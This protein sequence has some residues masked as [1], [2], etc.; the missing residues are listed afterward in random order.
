[1]LLIAGAVK[2][3]SLIVEIM[4]KLIIIFVL[5]GFLGCS[6]KLIHQKTDDNTVIQLKLRARDYFTA[7][8]F[9]Q[10]KNEHEKALIE[11]YQALLYDSSSTTIYNRIAENHM[12]LGR[13]E[14]ALKY[15]QMSLK[16]NNTVKETYRLSADCYYSLKRD[17]QAISNLHKVLELDPFDMS[18]HYMLLRLYMKNADHLALAKQYE[19][20]INTFG[21]DK[22]WL[23][24]AVDIYKRLKK[25]NDAI[26]LYKQ[27]LNHDSTDADIWYGLGVVYDIREDTERQDRSSFSELALTY[28]IKA[29]S[30]NEKHE[31]A[32]EGIIRNLRTLHDYDRLINILEPIYNKHQDQLVARIGLAEGYFNKKEFQ[33]SKNLLLPLLQEEDIPWQVYDLLGRNEMEQENFEKAKLYFRDVIEKDRRNRLG[34]LYLGFT[35]SDQDSLEKAEETYR[36]ALKFRPNDPYLLMFLGLTL[37]RLSRE[38]EAL[39]SLEMAAKADPDNLDILLNYG[40][41]LNR[42]GDKNKAIFIFRKANLL[43]PDNVYILDILGM[44]YD[45][46]GMVQQCDSI[47]D[48]AMQQ[49]PENDLLMNNFAYILSVRN[50]RIEYAFNLARKALEKQPDNAAYLDTMG[51]IYYRM[52]QYELALTYTIKSLEQR[53]GDE[54][55]RENPVVIEHLGDIYYKL[56]DIDNAKTNWGKALKLD[57]TNEQLKKKLDDINGDN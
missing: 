13:F 30:L 37:N 27:Y 42:L 36:R 8:I 25:Y 56:G 16:I 51:W 7:G 10:M 4:Q 1:M 52:G 46:L 26:T 34:W 40:N 54:S 32:T 22:K 55:R 43:K 57:E 31:P 47:Y 33:R 24:D 28:Y 45:E 50:E 20:M 14:S 9:H 41:T 12:Y 15:L 35:Y 44:L 2:F 3:I 38:D 21:I 19:T 29:L 11:F 5:I 48:A 39:E 49:F 23:N 53:E 18:S 6:K 17:R